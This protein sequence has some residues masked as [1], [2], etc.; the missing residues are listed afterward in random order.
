VPSGALASTTVFLDFTGNWRANL[1]LAD[2]FVRSN[3]DPAYPWGNFTSNEK[4]QIFE[5][6]FLEIQRVWQGYDVDFTLSDPGGNRDRI[7]FAAVGGGNGLGLF[8]STT[9]NYLGNYGPNSDA[10]VFLENFALLLFKIPNTATQQQRINAIA[11]EMGTVASHELGHIYGLNHWQK[12]AQPSITP[13]NYAS[14][15]SAETRSLMAT[16]GPVV[17]VGKNLNPLERAIMDIAGGSRFGGDSLVNQPVLE[18]IESGDAGGTPATAARLLFSEGASSGLRVA[19]HSGDLDDSSADVDVYKFT[20]SSAG[21]LTVNVLSG[22]SSNP[23]VFLAGFNPKLRLIGPDGTSVLAEFDDTYFAG[24][25]FNQPS[26]V[27]FGGFTI[28]VPKNNDLPFM[29]NWPLP[30]PGTYYLEIS[31]VEDNDV[32]DQYQILSTFDGTVLEAG[33]PGDYNENGGVDAA[34]YTAWRDNL[35]APAGTLP[36]DIDGGTI[37]T[38]Q[39]S[40]WSANYGLPPGSG[41]L[42]FAAVP[43]PGTM[44]LLFLAATG[45]CVLRGPASSRL[46]QL[47]NA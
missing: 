46:Q 10:D 1:D 5:K 26:Y 3:F 29:V 40:T 32:G 7:D 36:N 9:S 35:G 15:G 39:Y 33:L 24:D 45:W 44:V 43:E 2:D 12:Y 11:V 6:T 30:T 13:A 42:T 20:T 31:P 19:Y 4:N 16:P 21:A 18:R 28:N 22:G 47:L 8:G 23:E 34:D 41:A 27:D 17:G 14:T 25:V 37:G 38:A